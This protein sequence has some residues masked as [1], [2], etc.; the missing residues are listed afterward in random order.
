MIF[1]NSTFSIEECDPNVGDIFILGC[2]LFKLE[3]KDRFWD[4]SYVGILGTIAYT[5]KVKG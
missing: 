2:I 3:K 4:I 5:H 1:Q